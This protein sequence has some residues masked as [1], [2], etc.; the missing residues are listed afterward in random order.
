LRAGDPNDALTALGWWE[1]AAGIADDASRTATFA[2]FRA[3]GREL[4]SS[5]ALGAL[6][7]MPYLE[8]AGGGTDAGGLVV[9]AIE[10]ESR[11]RGRV[12]VV[13]GDVDGMSVLVDRP[14]RGAVLLAP[15][16][17]RRRAIDVPGRL[18]LH[19]VEANTDR[20]ADIAED[21]AAAA[22]PRSRALGRVAMALEMLGAAQRA[23]D[24]AL[25]HAVA[26]EQFGQPI[27]QFQAV[28]HLLA[29]AATD[30]AAVERAADV[31][32]ALGGDAPARYDEIVKALAGRNARRACQRTLQVLGAIG[33]TAEHDHHHCYS[34]VLA[35]DSLLG[36][37]AALTIGLGQWLREEGGDARIPF[38][39]LLGD[40]AQS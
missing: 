39:L 4:T 14:G 33:F 19:E 40:A 6:M 1:L 10:R 16:D 18:A 20:P 29:W 31:A 2:L 23:L 3:Q 5:A 36:T 34:R 15:D 11:H 12:A 24:L 27:G 26:R 25:E 30:C 22:R 8:P 38:T 28:R 17:V 32:V 37:S 35:L 7:A 9:S 13:A 21:V